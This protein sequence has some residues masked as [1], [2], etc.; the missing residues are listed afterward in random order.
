MTPFKSLL[1]R[2]MSRKEFLLVLAIGII[3]VLGLGSLL[4]M[5][6]GKD[7]SIGR[8]TRD[9]PAMYGGRRSQDTR[10]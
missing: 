1:H 5:F 9:G 4:R 10:K 3:S 7:F 2:E 6:T 8:I